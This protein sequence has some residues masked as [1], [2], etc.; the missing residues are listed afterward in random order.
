MKYVNPA[1]IYDV[2]FYSPVVEESFFELLF[3]NFLL[4][5]KLQEKQIVSHS[6]ANNCGK[7]INLI[8]RELATNENLKKYL[9]TVV[10][11]I[12]RHY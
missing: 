12:L 2:I 6:S 7:A 11:I 9:D 3:Q 10:E 1:C 8:L 5:Y 4:K